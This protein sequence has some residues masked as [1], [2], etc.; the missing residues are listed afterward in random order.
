MVMTRLPTFDELLKKVK[1]PKPIK[2]P[3]VSDVVTPTSPFG[4][5]SGWTMGKSPLPDGRVE[6]TLTSPQGITFKG[7]KVSPEGK[8]VNYQAFKGEKPIQPMGVHQIPGPPSPL[9]STAVH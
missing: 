1:Q 6:G 5:P 9:S 7:L 2:T 8:I 4:L 3:I